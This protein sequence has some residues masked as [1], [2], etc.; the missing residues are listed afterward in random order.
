MIFED[1]FGEDHKEITLILGSLAIVDRAQIDA[2]TAK[3]LLLERVLEVEKRYYG[4]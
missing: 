3:F 1:H 2:T 4:E